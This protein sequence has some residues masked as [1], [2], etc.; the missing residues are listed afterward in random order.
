MNGNAKFT[1]MPKKG[2]GE[3]PKLFFFRVR[4]KQ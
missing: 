2:N 1:V 3:K 4:M